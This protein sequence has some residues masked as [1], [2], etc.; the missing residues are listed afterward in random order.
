MTA[1]PVNVDSTYADRN[2]ADALHQQHHDELHRFRNSIAEISGLAAGD[3]LEALSA[4]T[5]GRIA[6]GTARQVLAMNS[7]ATAKE[8]VA[9][10]QSLM[11]AAGDTLYASA[12]NTPARLAKGT[13]GQFLRMNAAG[14]APEWATAPLLAVVGYKNGSDYTTTSTNEADIDATNLTLPAITVP[15]S[16]KVLFKANLSASNSGGDFIL[17]VRDGGGAISNAQETMLQAVSS[18]TRVQYA[19]LISG[20]T[21]G[22][23]K[24]YKLGW[25]V[26]A[27]T[28]TIHQQQTVLEAWAG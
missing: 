14:T 27:G 25:K 6:K 13:A 1:L 20:L 2:A 9:S 21:P 12:A 5:F 24:T 8:W 10:L 7:A 4:S 19:F 16:G 11:T 18:I 23:S 3:L 26:S 15:P 22:D 28:G 17:A